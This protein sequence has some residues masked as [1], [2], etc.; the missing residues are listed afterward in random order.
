M[1]F[2]IECYI[3]TDNLS[4]NVHVLYVATKFF[5]FQRFVFNIIHMNY[6]TIW[7]G[8][9]GG[10]KKKERRNAIGGNGAVWRKGLVTPVPK[11]RN[12]G[13]N[14]ASMQRARDTRVWRGYLLE[15]KRK[16]KTTGGLT[17][18]FTGL[19][20]QEGRGVIICACTK[21]FPPFARQIWQIFKNSP[22]PLDF[23]DFL[24]VI[25]GPTQR[26]LYDIKGEQKRNK[27]MHPGSQGQSAN[28]CNSA[29]WLALG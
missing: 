24:T 8:G 1:L 15:L 22:T 28:H 26:V 21:C 20:L 19:S 18:A 6:S 29:A 23:E 11:D 5:S 14:T 4:M 12:T 16:Q 27:I 25:F 7:E 13:T 10:E 3:H 9:V 2:V 17:G